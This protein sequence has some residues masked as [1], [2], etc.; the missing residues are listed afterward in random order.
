[1]VVSEDLF[2]IS[3]PTRLVMVA[4]L[5]RRPKEVPILVQKWLVN[6][7]EQLRGSLTATCPTRPSRFFLPCHNSKR[8]LRGRIYP[9]KGADAPQTC[10]FLRLQAWTLQEEVLPARVI[11]WTSKGLEWQCR[12]AHFDADFPLGQ[13]EP[14]DRH[15]N[16]K[17]ICLS[18]ELFH[19]SGSLTKEV[20]I[21]YSLLEDFMSRAIPNIPIDCQRSR[22]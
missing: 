6:G 11:S 13:L 21:W 7:N 10:N 16:Y 8:R 15:R 1:V 20:D 14:H 19:S 17:E 18:R 4:A 22:V 3:L 2:S 9:Q 5:L 12:S